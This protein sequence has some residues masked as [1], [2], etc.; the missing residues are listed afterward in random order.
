MKA[1]DYV[2]QLDLQAHEEGGYF[3]QLYK[4]AEIT[5]LPDG[6]VRALATSILFLLTAQNPSRFHRLKSD[7]IWYYHDGSDLTVHM[8]HPDGRYET[9]K[10]GRSHDALLQFTV[11]KGVIFG[12]TVDS[13]D[14]NDFAVV[15]CMVAPA[16]EY[17]DFELFSRQD[18]LANYP[19]HEE[20]IH[21]LTRV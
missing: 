19:Q 11:P 10:I 20:I 16:F 18:L 13:K 21:R 6:R 8:I 12:S 5:T 2:K 15:S 17:E 4:S 9:V 7:E 1:Q 3:K 14:P